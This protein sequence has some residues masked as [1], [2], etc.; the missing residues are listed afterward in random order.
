MDARPP[1]LLDRVRHA[2]RTRHYSRRTEEA[3]VHWIRRYILFHRK[4]HPSEMGVAEISRFLTFLAV[5]LHVSASTQ[6]QALSA[7][8]F[9]YKDVLAM[10]IGDIPPVVRARTP[11]RLPVVLSRDEVG[12]LL[13]ALAGQERLVVMLLYGA[14]LR[15]EECL[16]L[17]VKDFDFDRQQIVVRQG[18]GQRDRV[19]MLPSEEREGLTAHLA[20]VRQVHDTDLGARVRAGCPAVRGGSE[21][22]ERRHGLAVAVRVPGGAHLS[23]S[24]LGR[25]VEA[26]PARVSGAEGGGQGREA[27]RHH[28]AGRAAHD[29]P[30]LCDGA[31]RRRVRHPHGAGAARASGRPD[32]D[33]VSARD[34]PRGAGGEEPHGPAV[35]GYARASRVSTRVLRESPG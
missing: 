7:L 17:R 26:S 16:E 9:L 29:A 12:K 3:Y 22:S 19:T 27:G 21:V 6:N 8:L 10:S 2:I 15:L 32:D 30:Q 1:K 20:R 28:E 23:R 11:Q 4:T 33:D 18:K 14:G 5:D 13:R 34:E 24:A 31:A 35:S 25:P